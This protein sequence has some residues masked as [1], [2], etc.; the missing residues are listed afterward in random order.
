MPTIGKHFLSHVGSKFYH[1]ESHDKA[2]L[3][4]CGQCCTERYYYSTGLELCP[5]CRTLF[6]KAERIKRCP[7]RKSLQKARRST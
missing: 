1:Y 4:L 7:Y 3:S 5:Q 6:I 2:F